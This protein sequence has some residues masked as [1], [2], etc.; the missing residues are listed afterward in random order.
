VLVHLFFKGT[1][2]EEVDEAIK[3]FYWLEAADHLELGGI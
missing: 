2:A 1:T 3:I